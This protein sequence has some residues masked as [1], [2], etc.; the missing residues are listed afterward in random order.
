MKRILTKFSVIF[1]MTLLVSGAVFSQEPKNQIKP[2]IIKPVKR[3]KP[4]SDAIILFDRGN[5]DKFSS[6][7]ENAKVPWKIRGAIF[8]V[9]S[10][11]GSIQTKQDFGDFQLHVEFK[12]PRTAKKKEGQKSGNSGIYIMG[13]YEVQVLNS[14]ENETYPDGQAGAV[15]EQYP[16][17]VNASLEPA[18]WQRYDIVFNAPKYNNDGNLEKP[19]YLTVFHNGVLI[20]NHVKVLGPTTS[21][22]KELPEKAEKGPIMLQEHNN[23]VSYRNIWVREL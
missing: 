19:P 13:K 14:Y 17:L 18:K 21:Y 1:T 3:N 5:L 15:Y 22:N 11:S 10:G 12:I 23:D 20:Q 2:K 8:T 16:P 4:P 6:V 9:V 7:K